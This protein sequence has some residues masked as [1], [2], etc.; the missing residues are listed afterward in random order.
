M[1]IETPFWMTLRDKADAIAI[2]DHDSSST[3]TYAALDARVARAAE[4]LRSHERSLVLLFADSD[5][6]GIVCYLAALVAGHAVFLSPT[7]IRHAGAATLIDTY[8]PEIV[9]W[10]SGGAPQVFAD[11]YQPGGGVDAYQILRR[12]SQ[13]DPPPHP[14]LALVLSTSASTGSPKG[15]RI[16]AASLSANAM[17]VAEALAVP[18]SDRALLSLPLSYVYGLSVVNSSMHAGAAV[19]LVKGT[20]ADRS[21]ATKLADAAVSTI[22][23]VSQTLEWMRASRLGRDVLPSLTRLTHAG[24]RLD[25]GLFE[26]VYEHLGRHGVEIYLMY[27]QTEACGRITVLPPGALPKL[28]RSVGRAMRGGVVSLTRQGELVY[29]GP[30]VMLG[31]AHSREDLLFGDVLGGVLKTGDFG[32]VDETG[33]V[34]ITG[35]SSR[36][37][38]IFGKRVNLDEIEQA[39]RAE[40]VTAAVEKDGIVGVFFEGDTPAP[41]PAIMHM[42]R[43]FQLPPQSFRLY[44]LASLPR[45][46][47]GKI[48][49]Q[50]LASLL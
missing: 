21:Y 19:A 44:S 31:Y 29:Q 10:G 42:A 3:L 13:T 9:I 49:Y 17:Q 28:H 2:V 38:K 6:G 11:N 12:R 23:C 7:G 18:T 22:P 30:G 1:S 24:S 20:F 41:T 32:K 48:C 33:N 39:V 36:Y 40:R 16:S 27:G 50:T 4:E 34:F 15:V 37:C 35:R 14:A 46:A 45:T 47:R 26:W 43:R 8:R 5:L 25:P